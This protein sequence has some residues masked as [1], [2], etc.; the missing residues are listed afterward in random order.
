MSMSMKKLV[1]LCAVGALAASG[2]LSS[3]G[4]AAAAGEQ[5]TSYYPRPGVTGPTYQ[6]EI[7]AINGRRPA[8]T[9]SATRS[10][11]RATYW[12]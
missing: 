10:T 12:R 9:S 3:T 2:L 11:P 8:S 4:V 1:T 7:A 5:I 6:T